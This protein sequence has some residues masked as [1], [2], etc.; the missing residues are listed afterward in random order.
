M[1][2]VR[3]W[4]GIVTPLLALSS[5]PAASSPELSFQDRVRA[6]EI[7]ERVYY[8]HQISPVQSFSEAVP[9]DHL[10]RKVVSYLRQSAA[11]ETFWKTPIT[12]EALRAAPS[13]PSARTSIAISTSPTEPPTA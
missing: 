8:S 1:G 4:I 9:A 2:R 5:G 10:E 3:V 13:A 6:Q 7:I 12:A 11:L